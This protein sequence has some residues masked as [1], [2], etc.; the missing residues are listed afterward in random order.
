MK[1][2]KINK[3]IKFSNVD[4]PGNR[5]AIFLQGC[6]LNCLYCHNPETISICSQC[7]ECV[8][9]CPVTA[10]K[11]EKKSIVWDSTKC[12]ECDNC[13]K[14]CTNN[15]TP[16]TKEYSVEDLIAEVEKV[17]DFIQGITISGGEATLYSDFL[18][19]F[20]L[21]VKILFPNLTCFVDTNGFIDLSN[22]ELENFVDISDNF[23]LDIK[24]ITSKEHKKLTGQ[25]N[26]TILT[27]VKYLLEVSKLFEVRTVI[28]PEIPDT[29]VTVKKVGKII[30]GTEK[31]IRY[32]LIKYRH[33]G[34][35]KSISKQFSTPSEK[36]MEIL[37]TELKELKNS[38]NIEVII[39]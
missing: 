36:E 4:G 38:E 26:E 27:N 8:E 34:V 20:F 39:I 17:K 13:I 28:V 33:H 18:T 22:P 6:N 5:I 23:M 31:K 12:V 29:F 19:T 15:S 37:R 24:A 2:V 14:V 30:S 9:K 11:M 7:G 3:I 16:K 21:K 25:S 35:R 10:L 32:K 1:T